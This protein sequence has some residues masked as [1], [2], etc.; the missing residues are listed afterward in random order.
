MNTCLLAGE[1]I[2]RTTT[3]L[4]ACS[5]RL[6]SAHLCHVDESH[7]QGFIAQDS[8]VLVPLPPLQH[9]LQF[10]GISLEEMRVLKRKTV[11]MVS[12]QLGPSWVRSC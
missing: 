1:I 4:E 10:V 12:Q 11:Q 3:D 2:C 6:H 5:L 9:N 7:S 8:P